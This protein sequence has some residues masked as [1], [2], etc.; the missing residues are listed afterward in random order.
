MK[1]LKYLLPILCLAVSSSCKKAIETTPVSVITSSSFFK[2]PDDAAGALRGMYVEFRTPAAN[3]LFWL[4]EGR[5]E[6]L[7]S[8]VAGTQTYDRYWNNTLTATNPGADWRGFYTAINAANLLLKYVPGITFTSNDS[9]NSILAQA[10][11]MRAFAYFVLVRAWGGVPIRTEPIE[12]YDPAG[13]NIARASVADVFAL[14][15]SDLTKALPLY[16]TITF[17]TG[18]NT[19][20]K[21]SADALNADV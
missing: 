2:T 20:S 13:V 6:V 8:A 10:Y 1:K 7:T 14:I 4:G 11:T 17:E 16:P 15:K 19:W 9:K 12:A 18:R 21:A 5:S 3:D